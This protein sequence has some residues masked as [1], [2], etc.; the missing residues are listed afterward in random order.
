VRD[1]ADLGIVSRDVATRDRARWRN[2]TGCTHGGCRLHTG[3]RTASATD[4]CGGAVLM[5]R[6]RFEECT[7][8][9]PHQIGDAARLQ[10]EDR[11]AQCEKEP[12]H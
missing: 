7:R 8:L 9:W 6:G 1:V 3:L 4:A 5:L 2:Y 11:Y 12:L 10:Q